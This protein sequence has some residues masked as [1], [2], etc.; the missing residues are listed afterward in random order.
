M[1]IES[2]SACI[3]RHA[4]SRLIKY[5]H[6]TK[7]R[8]VLSQ[9]WSDNVASHRSLISRKIQLGTFS[10][11]R[12]CILPHYWRTVNVFSRRSIFILRGK[13]F[14]RLTSSL[15]RTGKKNREAEM[16]HL[17]QYCKRVTAQYCSASMSIHFEHQERVSMKKCYCTLYT[18]NEPSFHW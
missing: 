11:D 10:I 18:L 14:L 1:R 8:C 15:V 7:L 2:A 5:Q 9:L 17:D 16:W 13:P 4:N 6:K 12:Y 3:V